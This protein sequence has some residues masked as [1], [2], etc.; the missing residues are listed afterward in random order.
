M[1]SSRSDAVDQQAA[2]A[3]A[4]AAFLLIAN[5][6]AS[7]AVRDALF[8][9]A[10]EV[11]SLPLVMGAAAASALAGAELLSLALAR[12]SPPRRCSGG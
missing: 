10:F 5:Q 1:S 11:R 3:A 12:R 7:R 9:S 8:L 6:V 4:V 2:L